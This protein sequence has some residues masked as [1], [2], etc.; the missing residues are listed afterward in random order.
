MA[1]RYGHVLLSP[2]LFLQLCVSHPFLC[3]RDLEGREVGARVCGQRPASGRALGAPGAATPRPQD[4][5][6]CIE[7]GGGGGFFWE[8]FSFHQY[9]T[10]SICL[11]V[12][13]SRKMNT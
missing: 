5:R 9:G 10:S 7:R 4:V 1:I 3:V 8:V 2:L 13:L 6:A 12:Y 11:F